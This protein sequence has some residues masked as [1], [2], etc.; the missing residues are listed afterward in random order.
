MQTN[1]EPARL[2]P[3]SGSSYQ[4][5]FRVER[6]RFHVALSHLNRTRLLPVT[7]KDFPQTLERMRD[8]VLAE[9]RFLESER[10]EVRAAARAV[11]SDPARFATWFE[12]LR[13]TGSEQF[14]PLF[15]YI[16]EKCSFEEARWLLRQDVANQAGFDDLVALAQVRMPEAAKLTLARHY[17]DKAERREPKEMRGPLLGRLAEVMGVATASTETIVWES[18]ARANMLVGFAHSRRYAFQA[19]GAI[20]AVELTSSTR[21]PRILRALDRLEAPKSASYYLGL[22]ASVDAGHWQHWRDGIAVPLVS[23]FPEA[24]AHIAEGA[25]ALINASARMFGRYREHLG[26]SIQRPRLI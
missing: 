8:L 4:S 24:A 15:D 12:D 5:R 26:V 18:L 16:A 7:R 23:A 11:P 20:G 22:D 21:A 14:D 2:P 1:A 13:N 25:L 17:W 3:P 10:H 9:H 19:I 6:Q